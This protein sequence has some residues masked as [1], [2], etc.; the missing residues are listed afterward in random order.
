MRKVPSG[1]WSDRSP[2]VSAQYGVLARVVDRE[3]DRA[4][5]HPF[6]Q[7]RAE[8]RMLLGDRDVAGFGR[9]EPGPLEQALDDTGLV[10]LALVLGD[11]ELRHQRAEVVE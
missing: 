8:V 1:D 5:R 3:P 9:G 10:G 6:P 11:R 4:Y 2:S 7:H